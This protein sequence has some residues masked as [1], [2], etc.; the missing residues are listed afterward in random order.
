MDE[1]EKKV[2]E[3]WKDKVEQ[4]KQRETAPEPAAAGGLPPADFSFF[5]TS[6]SIQAAISLGQIPNP[7]TQ[8][9]EENLEHAKLII[10]TLAMLKEKTQGNLSTDEDSLIENYLYELRMQYVEKMKGTK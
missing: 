10:D 2:D 8:K 5:V 4:E 3:S 9:T 6:L 7:V 1:Q